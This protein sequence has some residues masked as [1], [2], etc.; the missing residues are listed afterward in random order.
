MNLYIRL[1][2]LGFRVLINSV[3]CAVGPSVNPLQKKGNSTCE[4]CFA[5]Y[6]S[7]F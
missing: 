1:E 6:V 4:H 7:I 5:M 2:G 3:P